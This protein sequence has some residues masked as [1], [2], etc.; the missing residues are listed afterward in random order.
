VPELA[1]LRGAAPLA[2]ERAVVLLP[3]KLHDVDGTAAGAAASA[4]V[5]VNFTLPANL[6]SLSSSSSSFG[7]CVL[8]KPPGSAPFV[9]HWEVLPNT[10]AAYDKVG[11][12]GNKSTFLGNATDANACLALCKTVAGCQEFAWKIFGPHPP[13]AF[14]NSTDAC[15]MINGPV[16]TTDPTIRPQPGATS[17][18]YLTADNSGAGLGITLTAGADQASGAPALH[19]TVGV[20]QPPPAP[21]QPSP[22]GGGA[23][24]MSR[25]DRQSLSLDDANTVPLLPHDIEQGVVTVRILSDRSIADFFVMGGRWAGTVAW[26]SGTPRLANAS[27]IR[28]FAAQAGMKADIEVHSMGCGWE[29][30]SYT[31]HPNM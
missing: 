16:D 5:I 28:I 20:C 17:G 29:F 1:G 11:V 18:K 24:A 13:P 15:Y 7:A 26:V 6:A 4:D 27:Q 23:A 19:M 12:P 8:A 10:N 22:P 21:A 9:P 3:G 31:E 14:L 25:S 30:P 2:S